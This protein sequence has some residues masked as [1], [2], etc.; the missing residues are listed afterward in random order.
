MFVKQWE[1]IPKI[2]MFM[3]T[4]LLPSHKSGLGLGVGWGSNVHVHVHT[5]LTSHNGH[6]SCAALHACTLRHRYGVGGEVGHNVH[7]CI[8]YSPHKKSM[9]LASPYTLACYVTDKGWEVGVGRVKD[10]LHI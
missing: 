7:V 1:T 6:V 5:L 2:T 9:F 8:H 4:D 3:Q 10:T